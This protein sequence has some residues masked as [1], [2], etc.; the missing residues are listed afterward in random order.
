MKKYIYYC[1]FFEKTIPTMKTKFTFL[2]CC[3]LTLFYGQLP[4]TSVSLKTI[5]KNET[6]IRPDSL[7]KNDFTN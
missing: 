4:K 3:T 1:L 7:K 2:L 6:T 5:D